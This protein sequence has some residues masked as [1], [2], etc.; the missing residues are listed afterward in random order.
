MN[1]PKTLP[2]NWE[3]IIRCAD[4]KTE[5]VISGDAAS[6]SVGLV[7]P[8]QRVRMILLTVPNECPECHNLKV[9]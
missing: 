3:T 2:V 1:N 8:K 4:C 5:F 9:V 7:S 6:P